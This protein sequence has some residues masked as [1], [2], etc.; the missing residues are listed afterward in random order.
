MLSVQTTLLNTVLRWYGIRSVW[1]AGYY[2]EQGYM[3]QRWAKDIRVERRL[4]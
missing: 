2:S 4:D 3:K 1:L